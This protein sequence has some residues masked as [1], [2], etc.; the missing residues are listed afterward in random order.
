MAVRHR[1]CATRSSPSARGLIYASIISLG[2]MSQGCSPYE[3][4]HENQWNAREQIWLSEASQVKVR[5]GQTR[6]YETTDRTNLLQAIVATMQDLDFKIEVLDEALGIVSGKKYVDL[7][8]SRVGPDPSYLLYR[9]DTLLFLTRNYRTWGPFW[10]RSDLVRLTV[11]V[12]TRDESQ[13]VVRASTQF[14][15]RAVET[16]EPYQQFFRTLEQSVFI[17]GQMAR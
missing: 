14:Y 10:N 11:T 16:P 12:R 13:L 1:E 17:Q 8:R 5:A 7:E 2:L 9:P 3:W 15:L 4:R 6:V